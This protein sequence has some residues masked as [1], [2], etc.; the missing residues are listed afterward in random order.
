MDQHQQVVSVDLY[1]PIS[2]SLMSGLGAVCTKPLTRSYDGGAVTCHE[3]AVQTRGENLWPKGTQYACW[4]K[5]PVCVVEHV[6]RRH[7]GQHVV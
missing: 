3:D 5:L 2:S 7:F 1:A 4:L 6:S